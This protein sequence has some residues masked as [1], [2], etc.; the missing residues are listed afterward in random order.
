MISPTTND[1]I[2][3]LTMLLVTIL[4]VPVGATEGS[5]FLSTPTTVVDGLG[6]DTRIST[7]D[8][9]Q[10]TAP[11]FRVVFLN[12]ENLFDTRDDSLTRDESFTPQ[13]SRRWTSQRLDRK[14]VQFWK[15][16]TALGY[17]DDE[18]V[19]RFPLVIGMV[20][21]E[22]DYVLRRLLGSYPLGR[23]YQY[24][25]YDS[26]DVRGI[27]CALLYD[28]SRY[29]PYYTHAIDVSDTVQHFRTRDILQVCG[30]LCDTG[31][32]LVVFVCHLPSQLGGHRADQ[33]RLRIAHQLRDTLTACVRRYPS[34][35]VMVMG[36]FNSDA[37]STV[38]RIISDDDSIC[39]RNMMHPSERRHGAH[40]GTYKFNGIWPILDQLL[41]YP[42]QG[43]Y[44]AGVF[45]PSW[46]Q[47]TDINHRGT[48]PRRTY[49]GYRYQ[50]GLSDHLPVYID[51]YG[52][53]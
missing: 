46:L 45:A 27:D 25:H 20:E 1:V 2:R 35:I 48:K 51:F 7:V 8:S 32:T 21:V 37:S 5:L 42:P 49:V 29:R 36:D 11:F 14:I 26:P 40:K 15:A 23:S 17:D 31:D 47:T 18:G 44:E 52:R 3:L 24:V 33:H 50:G 16:M 28:S 12:M 53:E 6:G 4:C 41:T 34:A 22:N 43:H 19:T 13:G 38:M 10:P 39:F 30:T 9:S